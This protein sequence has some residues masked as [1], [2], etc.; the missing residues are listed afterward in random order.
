MTPAEKAAYLKEH[1]GAPL[2]NGMNN[3][4]NTCYMNSCVQALGRVTELRE[5]LQTFQPAN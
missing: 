4:G 2:P 5:A 1:I 3:L